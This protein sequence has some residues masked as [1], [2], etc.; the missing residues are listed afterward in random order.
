MRKNAEAKKKSNEELAEALKDDCGLDLWTRHAHLEVLQARL[1]DEPDALVTV[2][3]PVR[4]RRSGEDEDP[5]P[6]TYALVEGDRYHLQQRLEEERVKEL[7]RLLCCARGKQHIAPMTMN[8]KV[9]GTRDAYKEKTDKYVDILAWVFRSGAKVFNPGA[10]LHCSQAI[11]RFCPFCAA[12][13]PGFRKRKDPPPHIHEPDSDGD[14]CGHCESRSRACVCLFP[15][16]AWEASYISGCHPAKHKWVT[17]PYVTDPGWEICS[18]MGCV[19][20]RE[21]Q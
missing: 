21:H 1:E 6:I 20:Q 3:A 4:H 19:V 12:P 2:M 11:I 8:L 17:D 14:Y 5:E 7:P 13:V 15:E 10:P 9:R 18:V 16:S